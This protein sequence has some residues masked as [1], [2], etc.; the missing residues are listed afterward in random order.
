MEEILRKA[1][2]KAISG[3]GDGI[4]DFEFEDEGIRVEVDYKGGTMFEFL[5]YKNYY[6]IIFDHEFAKAFW[7]DEKCPYGKKCPVYPSK[8]CAEAPGWQWHLQQM[9]LEKDPL[10]YIS[11]FL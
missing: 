1:L 8:K 10:K 7:K 5:E 11:K 3:T 9:A 6:S 4:V 2:T